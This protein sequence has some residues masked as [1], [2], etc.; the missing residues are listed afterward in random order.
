MTAY[1]VVAH[2]IVSTIDNLCVRGLFSFPV[3]FL[4]LTNKAVKA[5]KKKMFN[6]FIII[7]FLGLTSATVV[8]EIP[9][10]MYMQMN[11]T[12]TPAV[13]PSFTLCFSFRPTQILQLEGS[14]TLLVLQEISIG[15]K[16]TLNSFLPSFIPSLS[17]SSWSAEGL[18]AKIGKDQ[19]NSLC[20]TVDSSNA[21][22]GRSCMS[23]CLL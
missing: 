7:T 13:P 21:S 23:H 19:W 3:W 15:V 14:A 5:R 8:Y 20:L 17:I 9:R 4:N 16:F 10:N 18:D 1:C 22:I 6:E 12:P 11:S 2:L